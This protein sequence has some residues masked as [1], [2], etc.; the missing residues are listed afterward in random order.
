TGPLPRQNL[1]AG[2]AQIKGRG[3]KLGYRGASASSND[4]LAWG[5][6][7][8]CKSCSSENQRKFSSEINVHFPGL[9]NLDKP[10]VLLFPKLLVCMDC[11]FTE[12]AV[13]E[14]ELHL[15]GRDAT[16]RGT[17][18]FP[19]HEWSFDLSEFS[20]RL[21]FGSGEIDAR[22]CVADKPLAQKNG[23]YRQ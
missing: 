21:P 15:L 14:N 2:M 19:T 18:R 13:P 22:E 3:G 4:G 11:G 6:A 10:P 9:K 16:T 7:M 20:A 23:F 8:S 17:K 1:S 5:E 12:F